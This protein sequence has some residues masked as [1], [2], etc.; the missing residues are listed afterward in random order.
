M[1]IT[2]ADTNNP[3]IRAGCSDGFVYIYDLR[4]QDLVDTYDI[5]LVY[6]VRDM[7]IGPFD[8]AQ[9]E[10]FTGMRMIGNKIVATQV[11]TASRS[12]NDTFLCRNIVMLYIMT[13]NRDLVSQRMLQEQ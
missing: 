13:C 5:G 4:T 7:R 2:G 6:R 9:G 11:C 10:T 8:H 12:I 1:Q 3:C